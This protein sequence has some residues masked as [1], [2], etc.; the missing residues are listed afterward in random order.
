MWPRRRVREPRAF[1][2]P[3]RRPGLPESS[4][5]AATD[6]RTSVGIASPAH[7]SVREDFAEYVDEELAGRN[8][9]HLPNRRRARAQ[10]SRPRRD[11]EGL[12]SLA[13]EERGN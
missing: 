5:K 1:L 7:G 9:D 6:S 10:L 11:Y 2:A 8:V 3:S 4:P 12:I 13:R